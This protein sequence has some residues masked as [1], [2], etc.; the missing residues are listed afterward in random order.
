MNNILVYPPIYV[1][2]L[3]VQNRLTPTQNGEN[4]HFVYCHLQFFRRGNE[5]VTQISTLLKYTF[6][7]LNKKS[8]TLCTVTQIR[9][10]DFVF[11]TMCYSIQAAHGSLAPG[12]PSTELAPC[13][14]SRAYNFEAA[15]GFLEILCT[16]DLISAYQRLINRTIVK[17][18][19]AISYY[20]HN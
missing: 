5:C 4:S 15:P 14:P 10:D 20:F 8:S 12:V 19:R 1:R 3:Q 17:I 7:C 13:H 11:N 6:L 9:G 18:A 16:P 2:S